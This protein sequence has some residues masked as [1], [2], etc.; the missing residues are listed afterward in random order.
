M[1]IK[2]KE[3]VEWIKDYFAK[4]SWAKFAI[5]G[6]SGGKDSLVVARLCVEA[7]GKDRVV[8]VIIPNQ[9]M[10]DLKDAMDSCD[11]LGIRHIVI[12]IGP[13]T[14]RL[15]DEIATS[16]NRNSTRS[17][18][19]QAIINITPRVRMTTLYAVASSFSGLVA[20]TSNLSERVV[21]YTTKWG[22]SI[23]DFA[24]LY[25]LT[26]TE[27]VAIGNYFNLPKELTEKTPSDGLTGISDEESLGFSYDELDELIRTGTGNKPF[28][29]KIEKKYK[30]NKHKRVEIPAYDPHLFN[31]FKNK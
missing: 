27:V 24:P 23:G 11:I 15:I 18:T 12:N 7:I 5:V 16:L 10:K 29:N 8:G 4:E 14:S 9:E 25:N 22:D 30:E 3:V 31:F 1:D 6:M 2:V 26:K 17:I 13:T 19:E 21:G 28:I 20:N